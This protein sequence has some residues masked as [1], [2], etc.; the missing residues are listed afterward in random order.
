MPNTYFILAL[1]AALALSGCES[2]YYIFK[3]PESDQG[4]MCVTQ[5]ASTKESCRGH[6][7]Q[8]A[9]REKATCERTADMVFQ[10]CMSKAATKDQE[11]ECEKKRKSCW[12]YED[13]DRCETEYR[14][15]FVLCGG[16][17]EEHKK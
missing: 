6:E 11:K 17:V 8:R 9:Q 7:I 13:T 15:C 5:C 16:S 12:T 3:A 2:T 10:A 4:R 1:I 14:E